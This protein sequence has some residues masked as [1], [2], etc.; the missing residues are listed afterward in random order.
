VV[1]SGDK[2]IEV[3]EYERPVRTGPR[4]KPLPIFDE[5]TGEII[6]QEKPEQTERREDNNRRARMELRRTINASFDV[7]S[8]FLTL[9]FAENITDVKTA[10]AIYSKFMRK[11]KRKYGSIKYATVIEFQQRGAVHYH[12]I[13]DLPY[14]SKQELARIWGQGF[15]KIN[16]ITG[17]NGGDGVDNVGAYV[18][19]YMTKDQSDPR[20]NGQKAYFTSRNLE[21]PITVHGMDAIE[22]IDAYGLEQKKEVYASSYESEHQGNITYKEYN[23]K[24]QSPIDPNANG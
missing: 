16:D 1:L 23:L 8:K 7:H 17:Q 5:D 13:A 21:R 12:M 20:L 11:M 9:T 3:Y 4:P 15:V 22:L 6:D 14:I 10:N 18:T 19:A 24:R 2:L